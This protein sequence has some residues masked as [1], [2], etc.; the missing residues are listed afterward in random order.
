V[1][2]AVG[3]VRVA[4][5]EIVINERLS[6]TTNVEAY[7]H[8]AIWLSITISV[9]LILV[10]ALLHYEALRLFTRML[11]QPRGTPR[12]RIVYLVL[13]L[14]MLHTLEI[15]I[16]ATAY[17]LLAHFGFGSLKGL[18]G[19]EFLFFFYYSAVVY[20]TL[21][22]GDI[23]PLGPLKILTA[24]ESLIGLSFITWSASFTFLE[25]RRYWRDQ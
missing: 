4:Q 20:T 23:I 3:A 25:M 11:E 16:F 1:Q 13:G 8:G 10:T 21:G 12:I 19:D 9:A 7:H 24:L 22:F 17:D 14:F 6:T 2:R 5:E 18:E 15:L